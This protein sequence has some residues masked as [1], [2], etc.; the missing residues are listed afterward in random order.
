MTVKPGDAPESEA[1][2]VEAVDRHAP[3]ITEALDRGGKTYRKSGEVRAIRATAK[4]AVE[5][6]LADGTKETKNIADPGDYIVTAPSGERWVVKPETFLAR[7]TLKHGKK[8]VY[9][10]RGLVAAVKNPFGRPISI[11]ASWGER[12]HGAADCMIADVID[13]ATNE[14]A[15]EPYL[16]AGDL[17][18]QTYKDL[19][20][21]KKSQG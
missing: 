5:T 1:A 10:A 20:A 12:Q 21:K 6:I 9:I 14:R 4:T 19:D 16:I 17:F 11:M 8:H 15:G 7:Y 13:P 18:K 3:A 2:G